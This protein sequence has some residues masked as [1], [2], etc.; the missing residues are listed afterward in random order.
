[1]TCSSVRG[2]DLV[3]SMSFFISF[4]RH[5]GSVKCLFLRFSDLS[6]H[7]LSLPGIIGCQRDGPIPTVIDHNLRIL[8]HGPHGFKLERGI[9][10]LVVSQ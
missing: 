5:W 9:P 4:A 8:P 10:S 7:V 6:L 1:M 3:S 2:R